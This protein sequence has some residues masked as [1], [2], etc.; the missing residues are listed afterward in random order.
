MDV[1]SVGSRGKGLSGDGA[2]TPASILNQGN[3]SLLG[4]TGHCGG[5]PPAAQEMYRPTH[6][7]T[8][9]TS[10]FFS[11]RKTHLKITPQ[12]SPPRPKSLQVKTH[13]SPCLTIPLHG[14]THSREVVVLTQ[15]S[16]R[17]QIAASQLPHRP[18]SMGCNQVQPRQASDVDESVSMTMMSGHSPQEADVAASPTRTSS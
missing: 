17:L 6:L 1:T 14:Q 3:A 7:A 16:T 9:G 10:R 2:G 8:P 11:P 12:R 18:H 4:T 5:Q 15:R 13:A